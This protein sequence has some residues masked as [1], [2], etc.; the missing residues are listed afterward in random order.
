[1]IDRDSGDIGRIDHVDEK[2]K[3]A[4]LL[5][6]GNRRVADRLRGRKTQQVTNEPTMS[7][8]LPSLWKVLDSRLLLQVPRRDSEAD[9]IVR[10]QYDIG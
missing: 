2:S 1:V 9:V 3:V 7:I 5:I 4:S 6:D 10:Y 8:S